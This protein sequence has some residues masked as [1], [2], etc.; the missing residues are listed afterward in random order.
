MG[1]MRFLISPPAL[2]T[3]EIAQQAYLSGLDRIPW[4]VRVRNEEGILTLQRA[5]GDSACLHIPWTVEG[6]GRLTLSTGT[7]RERAEPY[8]LPLEL[9]RGKIGQ[10]RNQ[11]SEW[12]GIGLAVPAAVPAA[13]DEAV[14]YLAQAVHSAP[15][16]EE[17]S[18]L[19]ER[20]IHI[21]L[22]ASSLLT[23]AYGEQAVVAR[24]R[25]QSR[26]PTLLGAN[27]G[28]VLLDEYGASQFLQSFNTAVIPLHW[29][30]VQTGPQSFAW[31]LVDKQIRWCHQH[32]LKTLA[33]P[34]L[35]FDSRSAPDWLSADRG[36]FPAL[37]EQVSWYLETTVSR[38]RGAVDTWICAGRMN[39]GELLGLSEEEKVRLCARTIEVTR[40]ADPATPILVSFDQPWAEYL[41]YRA[42]DFPPLHFADALVR[43]GLGLSGVLVELNVGYW[44]GG[45]QLRD[46]LDLS[47]QLDYWSLLGVPLH[48]ALTLPSGVSDDPLAHRRV[49]L[50]GDDWSPRTQQ[51]WMLRYLPVLLAKP[52]IHGIYWGQLR[53][54][55]P[56]DFPHG[57]LFDL[58]RHPK[59]ILR[60]LA[61][62]RQAHL[63]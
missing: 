28:H 41:S 19:A 34:L 5:V 47:R 63:Q 44:P 18:V 54:S 33:G 4:E 40:A 3:E 48:V 62:I 32:A 55:E 43:A 57:G 13:L 39:T 31:D 38:L 50:L 46:P 37:V 24:R 56:H 1:L 11:Q 51:A 10:I 7:L 9:A 36:V 42:M 22:S 23:T 49:K 58:R 20:A 61:S 60:Q 2:A 6:Y 45:T 15:G 17:S 27:L 16:S 59:P 53:D 21:A 25:A 12:E 8:H 35:Q 26:L 52:N 14:R 30:T 29:R